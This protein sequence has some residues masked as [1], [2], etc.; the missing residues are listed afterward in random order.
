MPPGLI[1]PLGEDE[2]R[3]LIAYLMAGGDPDHPI[4]QEGNNSASASAE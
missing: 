4:Y 2:L 1:N 3:D